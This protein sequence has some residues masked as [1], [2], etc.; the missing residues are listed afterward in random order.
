MQMQIL[1]YVYDYVFVYVYV[2][3]YSSKRGRHAAPYPSTEQR[4]DFF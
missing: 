1:H 4:E 2:Y 3:E